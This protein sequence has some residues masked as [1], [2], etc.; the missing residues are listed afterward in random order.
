MDIGALQI[1]KFLGHRMSVLMAITTFP[2]LV[3]KN[4][5]GYSLFKKWVKGFNIFKTKTLCT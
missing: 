2:L 4:N 5:S 1:A 3:P